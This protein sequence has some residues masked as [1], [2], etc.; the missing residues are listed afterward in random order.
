VAHG[1][2]IEATTVLE[3]ASR[4]GASAELEVVREIARLLASKTDEPTPTFLDATHATPEDTSPDLRVQLE[5]SYDSI[6]E[7]VRARA[8]PDAV[9]KLE[10]V[11]ERLRRE[12]GGEWAFLEG[13]LRYQTQETD[14]AIERFEGLIRDQP[15]A[16]VR[17]P[18]LHYFL[19][20][21]H[22]AL[23]HFDKGVRNMRVYVEARASFHNLPPAL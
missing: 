10:R 13:Y 4:S 5:A 12:L 17:H 8:W 21:S 9:L 14:D 11:P 15:D 16:G 1:R 22:D 19:A 7:A 6:L 23:L 3:L 18:E 20:R 2:N